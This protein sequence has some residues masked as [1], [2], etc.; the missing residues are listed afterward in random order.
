MRTS[1]F[2]GVLLTFLMWGCIS[3]PEDNTAEQQVEPVSATVDTVNSAPTVDEFGIPV[4]SV[5]IQK[6]IVKR[7]ESLYLILDK[8]DFSPQEIHS[9]TQEASN[10][11]DFNQIKPGQKYRAYVSADSAKDVSQILL[12]SNP[13]EYVVL[14]WQ[15]DSLQIY[16][17]ARP[18]SSKTVAA[19]G[20]IENSLYQTISSQGASQLLANRMAN[21]FAWQINFF[22]LRPG[23]SFE[24]LYD[25]Q[26]I[27]D[28]Y[29]GIGDVKAAEFTHRGETYQAYKFSHGE[30]EGY[31]N[32]EGESVQKA[33]LQAPF[34]F[35]QRVSSNFSRSRYHPI[36]KRR[37]PH[38]GVDYAARPGTPVLAV[39][40]GT[41]TQAGYKGA[42]GNMVRIR[43]NSTYRTAYLHLRGFASGIKRG[44]TVEQ[45]QVIGYVG[46]TGRS[47]GPHLHYSLYK[48]DRPVNS[49]T[50]D[51][52]SSE[53]VPD[54][55]MDVFA[56]VRDSLN[57]QLK[58]KIDTTQGGGPVITQV[59]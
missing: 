16:K 18:L 8:F 37:V 42:S 55:L 21:I 27:G 58:T 33:L 32:E 23:D 38:T 48:N 30:V 43:H 4:D 54:S 12:Q 15:Q 39:G 2:A 51:L 5:E 59:K 45:G 56:E 28:D 13:L 29:Y 36:L 3:E 6:H 1:F 9:I 57:R 10:V 35:S 53:A 31:F 44:V 40:D 46:S 41:V 19:S 20:K 47:T 34:K 14:D 22:G 11:I 26:F 50:V 25:K 49:R 17:A 7:N 24:V 52:P